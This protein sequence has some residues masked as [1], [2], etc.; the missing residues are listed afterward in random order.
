MA[1]AAISLEDLDATGP[2][3]SVPQQLQFTSS[4]ALD[5]IQ[6]SSTAT[7][8]AAA[9]QQQLSDTQLI[10]A[11]L[12][13]ELHNTYRSSWQPYLA[14]LPQ[15]PPNPWLLTDPDQV[16]AAVEPYQQRL[17]DA[18]TTSVQDWV[19]AV[20]AARQEQLA[21]AAAVEAL[22]GAALGI[23]QHDVLTALGHVTSRSLVSGSSSGMCP[24]IDLVNHHASASAPMLQLDDSDTL[25]MTVLPLREVRA[26]RQSLCAYGTAG[27]RQSSS[28]AAMMPVGQIKY[29]ACSLS[30]LI[31]VFDLTCLSLPVPLAPRQLST[32][33]SLH[34]THLSFRA[35]LYPC[36]QE[37]SC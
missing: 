16:L 14:S 10:A 13:H 9:A 23:S 36:H 2:L 32:L 5:I 25:V 21:A 19:A 31:A 7:S 33:H 37:R 30:T 1:A 11:A 18:A 24:V 15:Q 35:R 34:P 22:L 17:A 20:T 8:L 27:G 29:A 6:H 4:T 28:Q 3:I 26:S 12:A